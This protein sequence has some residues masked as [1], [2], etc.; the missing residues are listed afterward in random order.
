MRHKL[1]PIKTDLQHCAAQDTPITEQLRYMLGQRPEAPTAQ[2]L[3]LQVGSYQSEHDAGDTSV[4][5]NAE[6]AIKGLSRRQSRPDDSSNLRRGGR[7]RLLKIVLVAGK[8]EWV[9]ALI[10]NFILLLEKFEGANNHAVR[11]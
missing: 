1:I 10:P 8:A 3:G 6:D 2:T 11:S 7:L 9:R 5:P 4:H